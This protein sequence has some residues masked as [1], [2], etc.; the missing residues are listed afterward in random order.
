MSLL[1]KYNL[2]SVFHTNRDSELETTGRYITKTNAD[3]GCCD[4]RSMC[5]Q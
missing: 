5:I 3:K 2:G 4:A 1:A